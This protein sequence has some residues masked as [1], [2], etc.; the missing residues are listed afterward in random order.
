MKN[1]VEKLILMIE[2]TEE[3]SFLYDDQ[4]LN[5]LNRIDTKTSGPGKHPIKFNV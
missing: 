5:Y 4:T 3:N 1:N 2:H